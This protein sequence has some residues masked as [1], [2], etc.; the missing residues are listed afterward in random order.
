MNVILPQRMTVDEF[1]AWSV[2][3]P[4]EAGKFELLDGVVI[5]QQSQQ[6][7][8]SKTKLNVYLAFRQAI[9]RAAVPFYAMG[10][11]PTVRIGPRTAFE[12]DALV[13]PRP[14]PDD[15]ALE[16]NNPI[17]VVEV[18]SP[19]TA[20]HDT[21]VKLKRYFQ[22]ASVQHYLVVDWEGRSI[23]HHRRIAKGKL[24]TDV[25]DG[26][27]LNLDPPGLSIRIDDVFGQRSKTT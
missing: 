26:G 24:E 13:A 25:L 16:I 18:L 22:L 14:E 1:L 19:S 11:G 5:M 23:T 9:E 20:R 6:F 15:T 2:T 21:T 27:M 7:G 8:H 4:K 10:E 3:Q 17:I 12:P